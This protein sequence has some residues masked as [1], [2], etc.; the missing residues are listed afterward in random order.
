MN[1]QESNQSAEDFPFSN[2]PPPQ[3]INDVAQED[4]IEN[5]MISKHRLFKIL[6]SLVEVNISS[7]GLDP[8]F[9]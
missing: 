8:S 4:L 6:I 3:E 1:D 5:T 2:P 9:E 7:I